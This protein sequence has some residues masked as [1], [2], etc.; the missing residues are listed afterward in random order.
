MLWG[1]NRSC[2]ISFIFAYFQRSHTHIVCRGLAKEIK[3]PLLHPV[4]DCYFSDWTPVEHPHIINYPKIFSDFQTT[5]HRR[6]FAVPETKQQF[7]LPANTETLLFLLHVRKGT[8]AF[9][10]S[11]F[12]DLGE[13]SVTH[14]C[15]L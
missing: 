12:S 6:L 8:K 9:S 7:L 2:V 11:A 3:G 10:G 15:P 14:H 13:L 5:L 4:S 1:M